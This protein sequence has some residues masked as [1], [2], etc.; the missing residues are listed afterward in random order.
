MKTIFETSELKVVDDGFN[1]KMHS[2]K[3]NSSHLV[4]RYNGDNG[5]EV[6]PEWF[7][8]YYNITSRWGDNTVVKVYRGKSPKKTKAL[9]ELKVRFNRGEICS[10]GY[11]H[12]Q[13]EEALNLARTGLLKNK[14]NNFLK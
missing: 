12:L 2:K 8:I 13:T 9:R 7:E 1:W 5:I 14:L 10:Y 3:T 6:K 4:G 11:K